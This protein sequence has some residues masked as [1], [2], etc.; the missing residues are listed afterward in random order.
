MGQMDRDRK[1]WSERR[2]DRLL[3]QRC[4]LRDAPDDE[5]GRLLDL[6]AFADGRLDAEDRDRV[7][8][9][10]AADP[11][12]AAD[13]AAARERAAAEAS[14]GL[15]QIILRA[16]AIIDGPIPARGLVVELAGARRRRPIRQ[17]LVQWGSLAAAI[18]AAS[19]LGFAMGSDASLALSQPAQP[20]DTSFLP[21]LFDPA[22]GFMRDLGE[23]AR[24]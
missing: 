4:C 13:V 10:L 20:S 16:C 17:K 9:L 23:G 6:A 24:T 5:A 2:S 18:V 14:G 19:W 3:W 7:A 15:E 11:A 8:S 1:E 22:T 12:A 21:E